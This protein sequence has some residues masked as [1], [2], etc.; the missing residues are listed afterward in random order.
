MQKPTKTQEIWKLKYINQKTQ[1]FFFLLKNIYIT[2]YLY[3]Y[4]AQPLAIS[5]LPLDFVLQKLMVLVNGLYSSVWIKDQPTRGKLGAV[6]LQSNTRLPVKHIKEHFSHKYWE[7]RTSNRPLFFLGILTHMCAVAF[8][9]EENK[10]NIIII[11][12]CNKKLRCTFQMRSSQIT[13]WPA[14]TASLP[15]PPPLYKCNMIPLCG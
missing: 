1:Y 13:W 9:R 6:Q 10:S 12:W 3:I 14:P 7:K 5:F 11:F 8:M 2:I 4:I 15:P